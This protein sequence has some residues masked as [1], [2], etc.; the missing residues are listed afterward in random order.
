MNEKDNAKHEKFVR[1]ATARANRAA[2]AI[3]LVG[4]CGNTSAYSYSEAEKK[5]IFA[6][7]RKALREAESKYETS[8]NSN[9]LEL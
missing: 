8:S 5:K 2:E 9:R 6:F 4:Q 3:R 1:I 7:L